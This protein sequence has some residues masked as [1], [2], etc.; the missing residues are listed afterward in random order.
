MYIYNIY[1]IS[2]WVKDSKNLIW[3]SVVFRP[4]MLGLQYVL[5]LLR[6]LKFFFTFFWKSKKRDFLSFTFFLFAS[7]VFSNY[8]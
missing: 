1:D 3:L 5:L 7:H 8:G 4:K 2:S 6:F